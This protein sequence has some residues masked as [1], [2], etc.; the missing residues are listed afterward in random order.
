MLFIYLWADGH[1]DRSYFLTLVSNAAM[2]IHVQVLV[3]TYG[4]ISLRYLGGEMPG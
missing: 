1:L 3:W 2:N 4:S